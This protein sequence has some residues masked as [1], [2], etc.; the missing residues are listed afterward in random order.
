MIGLHARGGTPLGFEQTA[1]LD[2][3]ADQHGFVVAYLSSLIPTSPA[4]TRADMPANL[5]YV[6]SEISQLIAAQNIDPNRVYVTGFSAGATM[7]FAV[8]CQLSRQ[9]A[10]IAAVSGAMRFTDPCDKLAHPVSEMS[11]IGT[12]DA[13]PIN[14][15]QVLPVR[16]SRRSALARAELLHRPTELV[17]VGS[18][19]DD[20]LEQL[21]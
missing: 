3:V 8:G 13:I 2:A 11:I 9:V 5:A 10:G 1:G 15:S 18:S 12:R 4:W 21:Q 7:A 6:S 17:G 16:L 20:G 14:G 19:H